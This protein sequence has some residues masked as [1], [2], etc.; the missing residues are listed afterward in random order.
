MF[1]AAFLIGLILMSGVARLY[2]RRRFDPSDH[3]A[4]INQ[5]LERNKQVPIEHEK[6]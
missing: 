4:M 2:L 3:I 6:R 5:A 1:V